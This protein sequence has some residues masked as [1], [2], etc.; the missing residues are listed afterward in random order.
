[1]RR[2]GLEA[3]CPWTRWR[4]HRAGHGQEEG[5]M[6]GKEGHGHRLEFH[7]LPSASPIT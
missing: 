4:H 2:P 5:E 1:M 3:D 7:L 6:E